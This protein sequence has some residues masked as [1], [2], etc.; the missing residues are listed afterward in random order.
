M[1]VIAI[2]LFTQGLVRPFYVILMA[3]A[4]IAL[5]TWFGGWRIVHTNGM[6]IMKLRPFGGFNAE[7]AAA[8]TLFAAASPEVPVST[9]HTI[10]G[11]IIGVGATRRLSAVCWGSCW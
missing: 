3:Q 1:G 2:L 5:R 4:A 11:A 6:K 8:S 9:T 7:T 10:A